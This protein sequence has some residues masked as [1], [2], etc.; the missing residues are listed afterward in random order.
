MQQ[1]SIQRNTK[2]KKHRIV[3]RGGKH[4]KTSGRGT[5]GQHARSG[6]KLRP[7]IRD[8]I[9]K[10]PK[11][12]GRGKNSL[13]KYSER[14]TPIN[15]SKIETYF[16]TG[17]LVSPKSLIEKKVIS[18]NRGRI[19]KIKVLGSGDLTK[20]LEFKGVFLSDSAKE[21]IEKAGGKIL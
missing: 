6:R 16:S 14:F 12:R 9:K 20:K 18:L 11:L 19:P 15:L 3:G 13:K 21:K 8:I 5:K 1:H 7:E 2:R 4:A 10:I 17:D